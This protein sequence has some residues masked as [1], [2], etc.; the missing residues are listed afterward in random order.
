M[1]Q[2]GKKNEP[3]VR[4]ESRWER[5]GNREWVALIEGSLPLV[6]DFIYQGWHREADTIDPVGCGIH[7]PGRVESMA[8]Q[9]IHFSF[10]W[11]PRPFHANLALFPI[12]PHL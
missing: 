1:G 6:I 3:V 8:I 12:V 7:P 10:P 5:D 2:G 11:A 4:V 9:S